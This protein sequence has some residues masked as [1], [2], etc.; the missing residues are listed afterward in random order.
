MIGAGKLVLGSE[1]CKKEFCVIFLCSSCSRVILQCQSRTSSS[2]QS[3][4]KKGG[5]GRKDLRDLSSKVG[6][7]YTHYYFEQEL[8]TGHFFLA[9]TILE[10]RGCVFKCRRPIFQAETT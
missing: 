2:T 10:F 5:R 4:W 9:F 1:R 8:K 7:V 3:R 6:G